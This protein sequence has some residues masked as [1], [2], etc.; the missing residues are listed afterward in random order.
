[1]TKVSRIFAL[2]IAIAVQWVATDANAQCGSK[3]FDEYGVFLGVGFSAL[4]ITM[5]KSTPSTRFTS[6]SLRLDSI[7]GTSSTAGL[8]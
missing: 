5:A 3:N 1:M 2:V 7:S 6:P 8:V 4:G